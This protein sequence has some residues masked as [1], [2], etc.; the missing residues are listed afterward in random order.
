MAALELA[1]LQEAWPFDEEVGWSHLA[2]VRADREGRGQ[3]I[4]GV[5]PCAMCVT[6]THQDLRGACL[7]GPASKS[8]CWSCDTR[9]EICLAIPENLVG[10]AQ[11]VSLFSA[12]AIEEVHAIRQRGFGHVDARQVARCG[13]VLRVLEGL[14]RCLRKCIEEED[15]Y[16]LKKPT[17]GEQQVA[18]RQAA[19]R[20]IAVTT[21]ALVRAETGN[22]MTPEELAQQTAAALAGPS[23]ESFLLGEIDRLL[24]LA[25]THDFNAPLGEDDVEE[26]WF[27][28][29]SRQ[30]EE[31]RRQ[32]LRIGFHLWDSEFGRIV[33]R[34][35]YGTPE[36]LLERKHRP[37]RRRRRQDR[38]DVEMEEAQE[39]AAAAPVAHDAEVE[40]NAEQDVPIARDAQAQEAVND[41]DESVLSD[42]RSSQFDDEPMNEALARRAL[43]REVMNL[44]SD[45]SSVGTADLVSD[46]EEDEDGD[47]EE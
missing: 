36:E 2:R 22:P 41:D 47:N 20:M 46:S 42:A 6:R 17:L 44:G 26:D 30:D 19:T 1:R 3:E 45:D 31:G 5:A 15:E 32:F 14:E 10:V 33:R 9:H 40:A 16:S 13:R 12:R 24:R 43:L 29:W 4:P 18:S 39:V 7:C 35:G 34:G 11:T 27:D 8:R 23:R 37:P 28:A 25:T 38:E 21:A